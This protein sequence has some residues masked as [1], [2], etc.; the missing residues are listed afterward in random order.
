MMEQVNNYYEDNFAVF[1]DD[2]D[3]ELDND[4]WDSYDPE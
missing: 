3:A 2:M 1:L 4:F